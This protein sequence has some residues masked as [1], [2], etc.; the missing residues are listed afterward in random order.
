MVAVYDIGLVSLPAL[1]PHLKW[2]NVSF[3]SRALLKAEWVPVGHH[4]LPGTQE[5]FGHA[6]SPS[7]GLAPS[8]ASTPPIPAS[9]AIFYDDFTSSV[10]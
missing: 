10:I 2:A 7:P 4:L 3:V 6:S 1:H 8:C 5:G 9:F